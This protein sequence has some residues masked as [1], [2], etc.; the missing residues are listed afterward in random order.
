MRMSKS[1][2][3]QL[4]T[5]LTDYL[6]K[7]TT[8]IASVFNV[9]GAET[10]E[11]LKE[12][13]PR[14]KGSRSGEYAQS[15]TLKKTGKRAK[16]NTFGRIRCTVYNKD[17]YRL[18]HLLEHGHIVRNQYGTPKREGAQHRAQAKPHIKQAETYGMQRL[19]EELER[20]L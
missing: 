15:W 9:V 16:G 19:L 8:T 1:V 7:E 6:N 12:I 13:S 2:Q 5:I 10:R 3:E 20:N 18:T 11:K 14:G 4:D 17:H